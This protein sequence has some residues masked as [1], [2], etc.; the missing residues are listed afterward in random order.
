[1]TTV[2]NK[3]TA[4]P[5]EGDVYIGRPTI[6]GNPFEVGR[7]GTRE[8]VLEKFKQYFLKRLAQDS[9]FRQAVRALRG[10]RLVCWCVPLPCHGQI[11]AE[12]LDDEEK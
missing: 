6:F 5:R 3:R 1:M 12:Y 4:R 8:E 7:D 10:K 11:I 2:V 9:A